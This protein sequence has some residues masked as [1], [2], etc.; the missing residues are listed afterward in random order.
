MVSIRR[1][2]ATSLVLGLVVALGAVALADLPPGGTFVDDDGNIHEGNIE[3]I[4]AEG[5][6]K[7]C[8]PPVRDKYCPDDPVTRAQMASFL[9]RMLSLSDTPLDAFID[10]DDS[11]HHGDINRLAAAGITRGCNPPTNDRY[12]PDDS[13]TR[14]QMA[15]FLVRALNLPPASQDRFVDDES[16]VHQEDI[17]RLGGNH[18]GVQ[19][20]FQRPLLPG[21]SGPSR[22]DG[23]IPR[24]CS[25]PHS[26][27]ASPARL[28]RAWTNHH[29]HSAD[30]HYHC[31]VVR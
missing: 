2:L 18:E 10:D 26:D 30:H 14:A 20:P 9:T 4:F 12:C 1:I 19:S 3:A 15:S 28:R 17:N 27:P 22:S 16:S 25:R 21:G 5:I 13:V 23:V 11:V 24:P 6:T 31:G 29:H 7:G 8:N